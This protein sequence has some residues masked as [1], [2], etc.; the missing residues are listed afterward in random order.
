M[1]GFSGLD[2]EQIKH[3]VKALPGLF[4]EA[5]P[6]SL[7]LDLAVCLYAV[8]GGERV[9][10][11]PVTEGGDWRYVVSELLGK[12]PRIPERSW[13]AGRGLTAASHECRGCVRYS[14]DG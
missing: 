8:S 12:Y 3:A 11:F 6:K 14:A 13:L 7:L 4:G 9:E 10:D 2:T 5:D 1:S